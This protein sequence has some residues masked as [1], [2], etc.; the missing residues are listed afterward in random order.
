MVGPSEAVKRMTPLVAQ[1][2][3]ELLEVLTKRRLI[4]SG[5]VPANG[6]ELARMATRV[7]RGEALGLSEP[8]ADALA[9]LLLRRDREGPQ[10]MR[11]CLECQHIRA[12]RDGWRCAAL[13]WSLPRE[14]VTR[15]QRCAEFNGGVSCD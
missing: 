12:D 11:A 3:T 5:Y 7:Q 1:C 6:Q 14:L 10:D 15:L 2:K 8:E 13:R 4:A 9:D